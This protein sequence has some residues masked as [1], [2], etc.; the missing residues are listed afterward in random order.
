MAQPLHRQQELGAHVVVAALS[1]DRLGEEAGDVV[2]VLAEG[3]L[4]LAQRVLL[5]GLHLGG[6][7]H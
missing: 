7:A 1:L 3:R 4:G 6:D 2:R 5:G